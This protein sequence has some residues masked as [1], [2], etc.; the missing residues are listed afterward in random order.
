MNKKFYFRTFQNSPDASITFTALGA[1]EATVSRRS[2]VIC[3]K[4][5]RTAVTVAR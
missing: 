4:E 2:D 3:C 5:L 1:L